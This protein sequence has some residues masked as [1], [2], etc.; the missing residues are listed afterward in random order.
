MKEKKTSKGSFRIEKY[1]IKNSIKYIK[2]K[3]FKDT[4]IGKP[5]PFDFFLPD[6]NICIEYNGLQ[7][8]KLCKFSEFN[9]EK[10]KKNDLLRYSYCQRKGIH[11]ITI[12]Y[13]DYKRIEEILRDEL[14]SI[15][16]LAFA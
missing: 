2:E 9:L 16:S 1:L 11:L 10:R 6:Y 8:Y 4:K 13:W 7:H 15:S 12:P 3:H 5:L 14:L